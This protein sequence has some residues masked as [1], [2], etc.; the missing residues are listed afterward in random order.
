MRPWNHKLNIKTSQK[1][2]LNVWDLNYGV[3]FSKHRVCFV[4]SYVL[5]FISFMGQ[6]KHQLYLGC[7][8]RHSSGLLCNEQEWP[9]GITWII[10]TS[11]LSYSNTIG[12]IRFIMCII[13]GWPNSVIGNINFNQHRSCAH[14][15]IQCHKTPQL[16]KWNHLTK[17]PKTC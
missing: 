9:N 14:H 5:H 10:L 6:C 7:T 3:C 12:I 8:L 11:L 15:E 16:K 17:W 4:H 13:W 1:W 2:G